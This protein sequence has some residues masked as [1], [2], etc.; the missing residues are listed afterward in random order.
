MPSV[1]WLRCTCCGLG[2]GCV[3]DVGH[4]AHHASGCAHIACCALTVRPHGCSGRTCVSCDH[5]V[6]PCK[7]RACA[8]ACA[9]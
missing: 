8:R 5:A 4:A 6:V 2:H 7:K 1:A 9:F 3:H